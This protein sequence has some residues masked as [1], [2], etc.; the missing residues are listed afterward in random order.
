MYNRYSQP[1]R[2]CCHVTICI[3][4]CSRRTCTIKLEQLNS[5]NFTH[6]IGNLSCTSPSYCDASGSSKVSRASLFLSLPQPAHPRDQQAKGDSDASLP[7]NGLVHA[8]MSSA[9]MKH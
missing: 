7:H 2:M 5:Y 9:C 4:G 6:N 1:G 3:S 8:T